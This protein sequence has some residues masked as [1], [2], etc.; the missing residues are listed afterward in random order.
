M[1]GERGTDMSLRWR[2]GLASALAIGALALVG[3]LDEDRGSVAFVAAPTSAPTSS[4]TTSST[5]AAS[6]T[7]TSPVRPATTTIASTTS[8]AVVRRCADIGFTPNSEDLASNIVAMG[9]SCVEAEALV[10]KVG[11]QVG[12]VGGPSRVEVDGFV[13]VRTAQRD[14]GLPSSDFSCTS[15]TKSLTFVRT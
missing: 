12:A 5:V 1:N 7:T 2:V 9:M 4:S 6:T 13:C 10:R 8:T 3:C 15:G 14:R 11:P